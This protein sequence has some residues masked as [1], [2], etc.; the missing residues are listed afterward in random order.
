[1]VFWATLTITAA[2]LLV[3][4]MA[5]AYIQVANRLEERDLEDSFGVDYSQ[6][7]QRV[8]RFVPSIGK[9]KPVPQAV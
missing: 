8:T 3:A 6:Y 9:T 1:M 4:V 2:H 5:S 7:K